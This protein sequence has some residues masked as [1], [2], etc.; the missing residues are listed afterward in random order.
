MVKMMLLP[1]NVAFGILPVHGCL[2]RTYNGGDANDSR[3]VRLGRPADTER[4]LRCT[5]RETNQVCA[6]RGRDDDQR[7]GMS[8]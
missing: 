7:L 2:R 1:L 8:N 5:F 6:T 3:R 4:G